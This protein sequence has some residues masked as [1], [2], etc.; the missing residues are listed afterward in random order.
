MKVIFLDVDGVLNSAQDGYSIRL[1]TD[2]HLKLLQY[3]V[4][5]TGAKIVLSSSWRIGLAKEV[6]RIGD[7]RKYEPTSVSTNR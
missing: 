6:S 7:N 5:E 4:K 3:I 1:K 2:S